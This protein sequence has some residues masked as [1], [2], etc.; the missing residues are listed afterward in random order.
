MN[1]D[2]WRIKVRDLVKSGP[3]K[4]SRRFLVARIR[5]PATSAAVSRGNARWE[6]G[7]FRGWLGNFLCLLNSSAGNEFRNLATS[8]AGNFSFAY[9]TQMCAVIL[10]SRL[11][12]QRGMF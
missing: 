3:W 2:E 5:L 9:F 4:V 11:L 10:F 1:G 6:S 8:R 12:V 7:L